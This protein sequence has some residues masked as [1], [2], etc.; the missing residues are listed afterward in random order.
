MKQSFDFNQ[1]LSG[2]TALVTGGTKG[3]G[4]AI[5]RRLD[6]AGAKVIIT[7]RNEPK[8]FGEFHFISADISQQKD[9]EHLVSEVAKHFGTIDIL[10]NNVGGSDT[11]SG[12]FGVLTNE[13]W[14]RIIQ[15]NLLGPVRLDKA[16][17]PL[18][19]EH[20][21]GVIIHVAS[22]QARLPLYDSSL[23]YAAA[24]AG[25]VNYSKGLSKEVS[26]K[27]VRI[28]SVSPGWMLTDS[29]KRWIDLI[30]ETSGI[31]PEQAK[32]NVM[33]EL[34]GIPIGRP[35]QPEEVAEL[36]GFLVS[37]RASYITGTEY[38]IDG[39]VIPTI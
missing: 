5:A 7:A 2:R 15:K 1:E 31:T 4:N 8:D 19:I 23:P 34:G 37:D 32:Q 11:P 6:S 17:L 33:D 25:L 24:K 29:A 10:V 26:S 30:A 16:L 9:V 27:G 38:V 3:L 12:G 20:G 28:V 13:D 18:M 22:V 14:E 36:V 35:A 21:N 39:G